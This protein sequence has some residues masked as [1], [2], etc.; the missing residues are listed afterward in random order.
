MSQDIRKIR[1]HGSGFGSC[2]FPGLVVLGGVDGELAEELAGDGV[3]DADV[4]D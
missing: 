3:D 1:T 4:S 2:S